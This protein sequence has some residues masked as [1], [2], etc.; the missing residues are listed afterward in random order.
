MKFVTKTI[1][2]RIGEWSPIDETFDYIDSGVYPNNPETRK[3]KWDK[4]LCCAKA[5]EKWLINEYYLLKPRRIVHI[6]MYDGWPYWKP[7]PSFSIEGTFGE[8]VHSWYEIA[9]VTEIGKEGR[10]SG[11]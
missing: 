9:Q 7:S 11:K 10:E 6:G 5:P 1:T 8:E 3:E 4:F 2:E